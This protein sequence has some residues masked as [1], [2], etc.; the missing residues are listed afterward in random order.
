MKELSPEEK[1]QRRKTLL[2]VLVALVFAVVFLVAIA[3]WYVTGAIYNRVLD[4]LALVLIAVVYV[5]WMVFLIWAR[6]REVLQE[7]F[8]PVSL[9]AR[10]SRSPLRRA[11][12]SFALYTGASKNEGGKAHE[13]RKSK[14]RGVRL[15]GHGLYDR[16][17]H[18]VVCVARDCSVVPI[19]AK[20]DHIGSRCGCNC[21]QHIAL[22]NKMAAPQE[23]TS[24]N[25]THKK[26]VVK[27]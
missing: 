15:W 27:A 20:C 22:A 24:P 19:L 18:R 4:W 5:A 11:S 25:A 7:S 8:F 13:Q 16:P 17:L 21:S 9:G 23:G 2:V 10:S 12:R 26:H 6:K 1:H 3:I 14:T